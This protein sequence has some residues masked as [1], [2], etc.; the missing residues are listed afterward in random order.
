MFGT[1]FIPETKSRYGGDMDRYEGLA[2]VAHPVAIYSNYACRP[3]LRAII[4]SYE[5]AALEAT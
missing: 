5:K 2:S 1:Y 3:H 4:E